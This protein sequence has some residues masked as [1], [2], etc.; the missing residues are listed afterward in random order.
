MI[1]A[2]TGV[3]SAL[4][5]AIAVADARTQ[6]IPDGLNAILGAAGLIAAWALG[7]SLDAALMGAAA[8]YAAL[9][10][11]AHLYFHA[12][13]Q[14]G[15][16]LGDAKLFAAGGAWIGWIGLPFALLLAASTALALVA[17][18]RLAGRPIHA[19]DRLAFG[20]FLA[21]GIFVVWLVQRFAP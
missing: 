11:M 18:Q 20:P 3:L 12:R 7:L 5:L 21:A 2:A 10:G 19:D 14:D 17:A 8:G 4:L 15:L 9:A 16:G 6:R 13:G 1:G